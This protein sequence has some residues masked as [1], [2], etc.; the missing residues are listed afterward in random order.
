MLDTSEIRSGVY[1]VTIVNTG[2]KINFKVI[3]D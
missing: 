1:I 3:K 2:N